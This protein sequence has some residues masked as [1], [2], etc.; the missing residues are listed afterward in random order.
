MVGGKTFVWEFIHPLAY[1]W[2]LTCKCAQ[3]GEL[4]VAAISSVVGGILSLLLYGDELT[5]GNPLRHDSGRK[6]FAF[7]YAFLEWPVWMLHRRDAWMCFGSLRMT[8]VEKVVGGVSAIFSKIVQVVF[9]AIPTNLAA[10]FSS[11]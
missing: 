7:Y 10:G 11:L 4:M 8:I 9:T 2:H 6:V 3:F 5:P 1:L